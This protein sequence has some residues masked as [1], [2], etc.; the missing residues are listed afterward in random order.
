MLILNSGCT[1]VLDVAESG[2][3]SILDLFIAET[4]FAVVCVG[5][6]VDL[7]SATLIFIAFVF[8]VPF[9]IMVCL[10][11]SARIRLHAFIYASISD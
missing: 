8:H 1:P 11:F 2:R 3:I 9:L 4:I 10:R 5:I 7:L 6:G